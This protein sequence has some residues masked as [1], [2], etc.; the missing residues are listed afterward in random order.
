MYPIA[1]HGTYQ[2]CGSWRFFPVGA[3]V[4]LGRAAFCPPSLELFE[5]QLLHGGPQ[6]GGFSGNTLLVAVCS[7]ELALCLLSGVAIM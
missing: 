2:V 4:F 1:A 6:G 3:L 5:L 7:C